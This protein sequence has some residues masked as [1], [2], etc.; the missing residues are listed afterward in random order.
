MI[1]N[2]LLR[3]AICIDDSKTIPK[4][5]GSIFR[6]KELWTLLDGSF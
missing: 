5:M 2:R 3:L 1:P 4:W 6:I